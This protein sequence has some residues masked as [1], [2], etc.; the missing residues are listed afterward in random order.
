LT[1]IQKREA[2]DG[3]LC[4]DRIIKKEGIIN[5]GRGI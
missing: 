3:L 2:C 5:V 1:K 4:N